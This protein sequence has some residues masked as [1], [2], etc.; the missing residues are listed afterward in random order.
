M[1]NIIKNPK[2]G[3]FLKINSKQGKALIRN[4]QKFIQMYQQQG[5][6]KKLLGKQILVLNKHEKTLELAGGNRNKVLKS[7]KNSRKLE[8]I[9][10][11]YFILAVIGKYR[12]F[13]EKQDP[14][15]I[16]V[17][18]NKQKSL[19]DLN[20]DFKQLIIQVYNSLPNKLQ[21]N[22]KQSLEGHSD[23]VKSVA[24]SPDGA[25]IV[26]GSDD[27]T[28]KVWSVESGESVTF[29]GHSEGVTSVSFSPDGA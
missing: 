20:K 23:S 11:C 15:K 2:T 3:R 6:V 24:F 19:K 26:S 25:S 5:G 12:E 17:W 28:V 10:M 22:E 1:F 14:I 27:N 18:I 9:S 7:L 8:K 4:Y 29:E 13:C 21:W 16:E